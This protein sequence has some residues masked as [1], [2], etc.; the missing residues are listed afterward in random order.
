[1]K[2]IINF[3]KFLCR[4][5]IHILKR[6]NILAD[7][8]TAITRLETCYKCQ[9]MTYKRFLLFWKRPVCDITKGGCGCNL[10]SKV[11]FKY[12]LCPKEKW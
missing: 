6:D 3:I 7:K 12:E 2:A 11:E 1:M 4:T 9:T 5:T 8:N 10:L